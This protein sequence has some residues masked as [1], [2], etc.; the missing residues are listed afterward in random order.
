MAIMGHSIAAYNGGVHMRN[1]F[2]QLLFRTA[3]ATFILV[4]GVFV[5]LVY[6]STFVKHGP[7]AA[8][9]KLFSRAVQCYTLYVLSCVVLTFIEGYSASYLLRM[10]LLLGATPFTDILKFYS[11]MLL[12]APLLLYVRINHGFAPL[13]AF[14]IAIHAIH[15]MFYPLPYYENFPGSNILFGFLYGATTDIAGPSVLHGITFVV[16][17][18]WLGNFIKGNMER[19]RLLDLQRPQVIYL[20]I[21]CSLLTIV[22]WTQ[23][24]G[25]YLHALAGMGFRNS[26]SYIYFA[27]GIA[28]AIIT[29][30]LCMRLTE[31]LGS[32]RIKPIL[33]LGGTS[34]FIFCFGNILIYFTRTEDLSQ[35]QAV[36]ATLATA[37]A[38]VLM[39][40]S[41]NKIRARIEQMDPNLPF[42]RRYKFISKGYADA[43]AAR[44]VGLMY[45]PQVVMA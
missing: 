37:A 3:P 31:R 41:Y 29:I 25:D 43:I 4:F 35:G 17:G 40:W 9:K 13:V 16:T 28:G 26:N 20:F 18:M 8:A 19:Y 45:K 39:A 1:D 15:F 21:A 27:F 33:F 14:C 36:A 30:D 44:M 7:A 10:A 23:F 22:G 38:N 2:V 11:I 12:I 42:V 6:G 34:L 24:E 32:E 5:E